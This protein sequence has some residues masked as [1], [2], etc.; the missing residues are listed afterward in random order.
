MAKIAKNSKAPVVKEPA[1]AYKKK[2]SPLRAV[3]KNTHTSKTE[4]VYWLGGSSL[5]GPISSEFDLLNA[6][7]KGIAKASVDEL[8]N[9]LGI[10]RKAMAEDIFDLSVKTM[11]RKSPKDKMDRRTSAHALEIAKVMQHAYEVFEDEQKLKLWVNKENKALNGAKPVF[12]FSTLTGLNMV[13][14]VLGRIEEGIYS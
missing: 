10:S 7:Q 6:G 8:A 2:Y 11:E 3:N 14:D 13:N 4:L 5:L 1:V 12:L 9:Y